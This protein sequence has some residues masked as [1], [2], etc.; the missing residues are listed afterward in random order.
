[1]QN[2]VN[3][4]KVIFLKFDQEIV[5]YSKLCKKE[6]AN[7]SMLPL[8]MYFNVSILT[9]RSRY[10]CNER[11]IPSITPLITSRD[12]SHWKTI[13]RL[14]NEINAVH[15]DFALQINQ[16]VDCSINGYFYKKSQYD[17]KTYIS[18]FAGVTKNENHV[19][20]TIEF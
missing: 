17:K 4:N 20:P 7:Y 14:M 19:S 13:V 2:S 6:A 1:M 9:E 10:F 15:Y 5:N 18:S 16:L 11:N 8:P 12:E 3:E